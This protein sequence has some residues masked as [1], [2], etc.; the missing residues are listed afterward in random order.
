MVGLI[1]LSIVIKTCI[2]PNRIASKKGLHKPYPPCVKFGAPLLNPPSLLLLLIHAAHPPLLLLPFPSFSITFPPFW[3]AHPTCVFL[4]YCLFFVGTPRFRLC[5]RR[6]ATMENL[7]KAMEISHVISSPTI[8][9]HHVSSRCQVFFRVYRY[10][11][12]FSKIVGVL[13][14]CLQGSRSIFQVDW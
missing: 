14:T 5:V 10:H 8:H 1:F 7:G 2:Y 4:S 13:F 9:H 6:G 3:L 12:Q 11:V